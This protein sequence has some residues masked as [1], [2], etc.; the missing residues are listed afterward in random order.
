M[1]WNQHAYAVTHVEEDG[2][3]PASSAWPKNWMD[4]T[5][6]NF[7]TNVPGGKGG[8]Y[9]PDF[10][11]GASDEYACIGGE[12]TLSAPVCNRGA[13]PVAPGVS[14]GFFVNGQ[15]VC[16]TE[17]TMLLS[18]DDC[19][20]VTCTWTSPPVQEPDAVDVTVTSNFDKALTECKDGNNDGVILHVFCKPVG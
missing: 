5:L 9:T 12:V 18:P 6:N 17:T 8:Q 4:P 7:R 14:V 20:T 2:T 10:T 16:S 3:V 11:T 15:L 1:I 19:E 13:A